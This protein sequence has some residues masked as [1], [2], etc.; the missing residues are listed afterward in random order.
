MSKLKDQISNQYQVIECRNR[1]V[2]LAFGFLASFGIW[3]LAFGIFAVSKAEAATLSAGPTTGTF[4]VGS[5]FDVSL[6]LDTEGKPVNTIAAFLSF[7][8]DKLQLVSPTTGK[9]IISIC[10][11]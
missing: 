2:V 9:S 1:M 3:I 4:T 8:A 7:P 5:T 11:C 10:F 6:F